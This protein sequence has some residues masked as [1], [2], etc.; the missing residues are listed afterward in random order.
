MTRRIF[1]WMAC[2]L[3]VAL[4][5][6]AVLVSRSVRGVSAQAVVSGSMRPVLPVGSLVIIRRLPSDAYRPGDIVT[7]A[8]PGHA[9]LATHRIMAVY[10]VDG[11]LVVMRTKGDA[12]EA[13]DPF[14]TDIRAV[15]GRV[16]LQVPLVGYLVQAEQAPIGFLGVACLTFI[17]F[18]AAELHF[19]TGLIFRRQRL[20]TT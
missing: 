14:V 8:M 10:R 19:V 2:G 18:V 11:P 5:A 15:R 13:P 9:M 17:L 3:M 7:F 4:V 20:V 6:V 12:N 16:E 1:R